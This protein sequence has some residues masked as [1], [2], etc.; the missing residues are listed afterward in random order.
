MEVT[1]SKEQSHLKQFISDLTKK[2]NTDNAFKQNLISSPMETL[3]ECTKGSFSI[4]NNKEV[5]VV[6]QTTPDT[7]YL[8]IPSKPNMDS[9][10]LTDEQLEMVAGGEFV[11]AGTLIGIAALGGGIAVGYWLL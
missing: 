4:P 5:V 3:N 2:C 1:L 7:I 6:D 10:E 9:L 11:V 8:N